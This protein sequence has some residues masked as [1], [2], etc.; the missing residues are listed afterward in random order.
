MRVDCVRASNVGFKG[1]SASASVRSASL[2][3]THMP[4]ADTKIAKNKGQFLTLM[5]LAALV[6]ANFGIYF[7]KNGQFSAEA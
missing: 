5:V 2:P 1:N 4:K 7:I 6:L 3:V